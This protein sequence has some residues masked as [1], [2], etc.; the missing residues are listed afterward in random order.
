MKFANLDG[1]E[2]GK[3]TA[4]DRTILGYSKEN[5]RMSFSNTVRYKDFELYA[6]FTGIFGG[7]GYGQA[8]NLYA[9]RT[10]SDSPWDNNLNHTWWSPEHPSNV[11]PSATYTDGRYTPLQGYGFVRLQD[12]SL[13]YTFRQPWVKKAGI[14]NLKLFVSAKNVFTITGW[15]GGDPEIQQ[16]IGTGYNYGYPLSRSF[17][18]GV[19]LSF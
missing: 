3:I 10:Y 1:S 18:F 5:F 6:L 8:V 7:N 14:G 17:S 13:S 4:E 19:N 2:D 15:E 12:L 9:F 16:T 11:Y